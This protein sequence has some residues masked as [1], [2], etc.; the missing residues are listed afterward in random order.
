ASKARTVQ[1]AHPAK[2]YARNGDRLFYLGGRPTAETWA[3]PLL[4]MGMSTYSSAMFNFVPEFALE[5][6]RAVRA[7]DRAAVT[8]KLSRFVLPYLDI[9][10][11]GRGY[12]VS[13][14]KAGLRVTGRGV[15]PVRPPLHDL[16]AQDDADLLALIERSGVLSAVPA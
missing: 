13:I 10:N 1:I 12:G 5:F 4:Q 3:L 11:R 6:Y 14:V 8:E 16:S 15:G 2:G 7:Q 9:R